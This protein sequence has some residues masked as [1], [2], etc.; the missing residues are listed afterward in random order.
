M[1]KTVIQIVFIVLVSIICFS[2]SRN[3]NENGTNE[4]DSIFY[5]SRLHLTVPNIQKIGDTLVYQ[6]EIVVNN[7]DC[8]I[9]HELLYPNVFFYHYEINPDCYLGKKD[10]I[11]PDSIRNHLKINDRIYYIDSLFEKEKGEPC[12]HIATLYFE[13]FLTTFNNN[14]YV[15]VHFCYYFG[16]SF[17]YINKACLIEE[18]PDKKLSFYVVP[19]LSDSA[20]EYALGDFNQDNYLDFAPVKNDTVFLYSLINNEFVLQKDAY[21]KLIEMGEWEMGG[22]III[23]FKNS[24][25]KFPDKK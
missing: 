4:Q 8:Q 11:L 6:K 25:W 15:L 1:Y 24:R 10:F 2:L 18:T 5:F 19:C 9:L 23:D 16:N 13:L 14:K 17:T 12:W 7:C 3:N 22:P 20:S 21:I